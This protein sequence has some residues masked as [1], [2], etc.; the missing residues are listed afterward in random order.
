MILIAAV[1]TSNQRDWVRLRCHGQS[2]L[3][4]Q[5][6]KEVDSSLHREKVRCIPRTL[7][8]SV[9]AVA[10]LP[11]RETRTTCNL[12]INS[13]LFF[14]LSVSFGLSLD[15]ESPRD[16][17]DRSRGRGSKAKFRSSTRRRSREQASLSSQWLLIRSLA[18]EDPNEWKAFP[19]VIS[20]LIARRVTAFSIDR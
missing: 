12:G 16:S 13:Y 8:E 19:F 3:Y 6:I 7:C 1:G 9:V 18:D 5:R 20:S 17:G 10:R 14:F 4:Y 11:Q 15:G 2:C